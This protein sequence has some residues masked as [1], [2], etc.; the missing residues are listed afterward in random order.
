MNLKRGNYQIFLE[1][2]EKK[3]GKYFNSPPAVHKKSSKQKQVTK[4][5]FTI[6]S[7]Q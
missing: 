3:L 5:C 7:S 1:I 2:G 6:L 4:N